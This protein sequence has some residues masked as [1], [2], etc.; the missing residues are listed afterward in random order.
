MNQRIFD[1]INGP[2]G[3]FSALDSLADK[4]GRRLRDGWSIGADS[5]DEATVA[6][7]RSVI[8]REVAGT[9]DIRGDGLGC[10]V[11]D[12]DE[13]NVPRDPSDEDRCLPVQ[14]RGGGG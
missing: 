14:S 2:A 10:I 4:S 8:V 9:S 3:D 11:R 12:G 5:L 13:E 7:M 1:L 6:R